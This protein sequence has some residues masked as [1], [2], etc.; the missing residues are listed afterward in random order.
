M[1][2]PIGYELLPNLAVVYRIW[3]NLD[4]ADLLED[5]REYDEDM[6][7]QSYPILTKPTAHYLHQ[8]IQLPFNP[9]YKSLYDITPNSSAEKDAYLRM[10]CVSEVIGECMHNNLEGWSDGEKVVIQL[11]LMDLGIAANL[12]L[13]AY[14]ER[15]EGNKS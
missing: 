12:T 14:K 13:Q 7:R 3:Q 2:N 9:D 5:R 1:T 11:F 6:L 15:Q 4:E 8:L 10:S